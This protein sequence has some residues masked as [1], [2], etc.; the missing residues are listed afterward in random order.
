MAPYNRSVDVWRHCGGGTLWTA[1][2]TKM[3]RRQR[4]GGGILNLARKAFS[5][6]RHTVGPLVKR[7]GMPLLRYSRDYVLRNADTFRRAYSS[8]GTSNLLSTVISTVPTVVN[9][10]HAIYQESKDGPEVRGGFFAALPGII[11]A[12]ISAAKPL[13][14]AAA[15]SVLPS[16][17]GAAVNGRGGAVITRG[18]LNTLQTVMLAAAASTLSKDDQNKVMEDLAGQEQSLGAIESCM[19]R[20]AGNMAACAEMLGL[21]PSVVAECS[22]GGRRPTGSRGVVSAE[23]GTMASYETD[24]IMCSRRPTATHDTKCSLTQVRERGGV[25]GRPRRRVVYVRRCDL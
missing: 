5:Y 16:I 20:G 7:L 6:V 23:Y 10:V 8:G 11:A 1:E 4:R 9:D 17:I 3:R 24:S 15:T 12:A 19:Q 14:A 2:L 21:P 18:P 13:L 22:R 25:G